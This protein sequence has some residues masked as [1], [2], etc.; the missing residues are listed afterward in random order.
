MPGPLYEKRP[1]Y[2]IFGGLVFTVLT[3]NYLSMKN[4]DLHVAIRGL[5]AVSDLEYEFQL[6]H[7]NR[8]LSPGMET[9]FLMPSSNYVYLNSSTVREVASLGGDLKGFVP[10]HGRSGRALQRTRTA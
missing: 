8:T 9:V 6:A 1:S 7:T 10:P 2:F 3:N 5:R 4:N